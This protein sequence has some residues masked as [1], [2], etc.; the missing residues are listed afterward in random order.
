MNAIL[1][2]VCAAAP[3]VAAGLAVAILVVRGAKKKKAKKPN[4]DY[5]A[6]GMS[7][8]MC[9]GLLI[10]TA[11]GN[12][13]GIGISFGMLVGLAIGIGIPKKPENKDERGE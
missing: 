7:L 6:E 5:S 3:W 12:N 13:S 1:D 11:L 8:G 2:F 4:G 10:G 9:F